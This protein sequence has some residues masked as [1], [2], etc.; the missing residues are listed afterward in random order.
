MLLIFL[1][2]L[3]WLS[4]TA[5]GLSIVLTYKSVANRVGW[6]QGRLVE[7]LP[8]ISPLASLFFCTIIGFSVFSPIV[9]LSYF[10]VWPIAILVTCYLLA[11]LFS[12][13]I[14]SIYRNRLLTTIKSYTHFS[15]LQLLITILVTVSLLIDYVISIRV[16]APLYGDA[17]VQIAKINL[18]MSGHF[19]LSDPYYK[20]NGVIDPRYSTNL[21]DAFQA[22][23]GKLFHTT[24][25]RIWLYSYAFYR[26]VIWLSVFTVSWIFLPKKYKVWSYFIL[27]GLPIVLGQIFI[28]ANLPDRIVFAWV[29]LL[30]LGLKYWLEKHSY[31]LLVIASL[32]IAMTHALFSLIALGYLCFLILA[33]WLLKSLKLKDLPALLISIAILMVPVVLNIYYPNHTNQDPASYNPGLA[34]PPLHHYGAL[35]VSHLPAFSLLTLV[36]YCLMFAC[37]GLAYKTVSKLLRLAIYGLL[38]V[39]MYLSFNYSY[40]AIIGYV[41]MLLVIRSKKLRIVIGSLVLFYPLIIYNPMFWHLNHGQIPPW[42]VFRFSYLNIFGLVAPYIGLAAFTM[43]PFIKWGYKAPGYYATSLCLTALIIGSSLYNGDIPTSYPWA[44]TVRQENQSRLA[45]LNSLQALSPS[46]KNQVVYTNDPDL[47]ILIPD[48][49]RAGVINFQAANESPMSN[50]AMRAECN[51][52]LAR[53]ISYTDLKSSQ[54]TVILTD[55]HYANKI[56]GL[57]KG[58]NFLKLVATHGDYTVYKVNTHFITSNRYTPCSIPYHG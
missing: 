24:G 4:F 50:I 11:L 31:T 1:I 45:V 39:L 56:N 7:S 5:I 40:L 26:F 12:L 34:P 10:L 18:F 22:L 20:Y 16:G 3:F 51:N 37:L 9:V 41:S 17:P 15:K 19:T 14:L 53:N 46:L 6:K 52:L 47:S 36:I 55:G 30:V 57:A 2:Q 43:L 35:L 28:Y 13:I 23:A 42:V 48:V 38:V 54:A 21:M 25:I 44:K 49:V 58:P 27:A 33:L 32:L 29:C 8:S